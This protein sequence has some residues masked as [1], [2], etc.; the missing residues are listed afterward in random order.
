VQRLVNCTKKLTRFTDRIWQRP[1][2]LATKPIGPAPAGAEVADLAAW[3]SV[4]NVL[5]NLDEMLMKR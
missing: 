4:A 5:L 3:T 1:Q 2:D